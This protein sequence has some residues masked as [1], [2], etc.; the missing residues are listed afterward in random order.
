MSRQ[1]KMNRLVTKRPEVPLSHKIQ[2]IN[3]HRL[4]QKINLLTKMIFKYNYQKSNKVQIKHIKLPFLEDL[5][6]YNKYSRC[7]TK[8]NNFQKR[9]MGYKGFLL[10][11]T[12]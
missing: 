8:E 3:R 11:A 6:C 5:S 4:L 9:C 2:Q 1:L 12:E 10:K 7:V